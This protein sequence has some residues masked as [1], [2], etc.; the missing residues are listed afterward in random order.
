MNT[1]HPKFEGLTLRDRMRLHA[2]SRPTYVQSHRRDRT[3]QPYDRA[4]ERKQGFQPHH[5]FLLHSHE[6]GTVRAARIARWLTVRDRAGRLVPG[7]YGYRVGRTK[8][9]PAKR[10]ARRKVHA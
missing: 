8:S 3:G 9:T 7:N 5:N 4:T 2:R 10:R 1:P 6:P